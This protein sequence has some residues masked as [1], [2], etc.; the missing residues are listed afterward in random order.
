[1]TDRR[2]DP[3]AR[4]RRLA[5][6]LNLAIWLV[7]TLLHHGPARL[8]NS[9]TFHKI[10]LI[11]GTAVTGF[12]LCWL[13]FALVARTW[14]SGSRYHAPLFVV[15]LALLVVGYTLGAALLSDALGDLRQVHNGEARVMPL[16]VWIATTWSVIGWA[17]LAYGAGVAT[18]MAIF[19]IEER[20]HKLVQ[21]RTQAREAQ[22]AALR[23]QINPDFLLGA[24]RSVSDLIVARRKGE[25]EQLVLD[26]SDVLRSA[27]AN[28]PD[29][30]IPLGEE[31]EVAEGY[32]AVERWR[33]NRP[34]ALVIDL[35][36]AL[37]GALVPHFL[38]QP[39]I[40]EAVCDIAAGSRVT[41]TLT[42]TAARQDAQLVLT[43]ER[44]VGGPA[45][46]HGLE[47]VATRLRGLYDDGAAVTS[48]PAG[49]GNAAAIRL[50]LRFPPGPAGNPYAVDAA[51][52]AGP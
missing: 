16:S 40:D 41:T 33:L 46:W 20:E 14:R 24:L 37:R 11:T 42:L 17:P 3:E 45:A 47:R 49:N 28:A 10:A 13:W 9:V 31:L 39:L 22:L 34:M 50:P 27:L 43:F 38:L 26:F 48:G 18:M 23:L 6:G 29:E 52:G 12:L 19:A 7:A 51:S 21:A 2:Y 1:M 44:A 4:A 15:S 25:A 32:L 8:W 36:D 30:L 35:P 5:L